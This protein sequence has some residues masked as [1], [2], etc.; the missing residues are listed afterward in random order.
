MSFFFF[1]YIRLT[2]YQNIKK[3]KKKKNL[4]LY[5]RKGRK[6]K[7]KSNGSSVKSKPDYWHRIHVPIRRRLGS[8]FYLTS[9]IDKASEIQHKTLDNIRT[10]NC[11]LMFIDFFPQV[12]QLI[13]INM[14]FRFC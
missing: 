1:F 5:N 4:V 8:A 6:A 14:H 11:K 13:E 9:S 7:Q 12:T 10:L 2:I 3:T